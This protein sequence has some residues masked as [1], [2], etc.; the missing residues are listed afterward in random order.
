[1]LRLI[2]RQVLRTTVP[3]TSFVR[4]ASTS[5]PNTETTSSTKKTITSIAPAGTKLKG[6]N[7]KKGG[8]DPIALAENEYPEWLWELLDPAAQKAKLESDAGRQARKERRSANRQKI[9]MN[10]FLAGMKN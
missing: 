6:L 1:M 5:A 4:L 3:R 9:K 10:N 8:E 7:I 2:T